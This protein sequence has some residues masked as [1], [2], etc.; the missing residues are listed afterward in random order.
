MDSAACKQCGETKSLEAFTTDRNSIKNVCKACRAAKERERRASNA[1]R[2]LI[3]EPASKRC[4][5]CGAHMGP[6]QFATDRTRTDGLQSTCRGCSNARQKKRDEEVAKH[7]RTITA[8]VLE[9]QHHCCPACGRDRVQSS[10]QIGKSKMVWTSNWTVMDAAH[11]SLIVG[12]LKKEGW[13]WDPRNHPKMIVGVTHPTMTATSL[14]KWF[15]SQPDGERRV[16][17]MKQRIQEMVAICKGCYGKYADA[18]GVIK[19]KGTQH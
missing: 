17:E 9:Q 12:W 10:Q 7:R 4:T 14:A 11:A 6:S 15:V 8:R 2:T 1:T 5:S 13:A 19:Q 18:A 3:E 16:Q